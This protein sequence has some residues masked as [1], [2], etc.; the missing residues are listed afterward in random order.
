MTIVLMPQL[1]NEPAQHLQT[2]ASRRVL[3]ATNRKCFARGASFAGGGRLLQVHDG[4]LRPFSATAVLGPCFSTGEES[5]S[6]RPKNPWPS[7]AA[8][9]AEAGTTVRRTIETGINAG[10]NIAC[11]QQGS[12]ATL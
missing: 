1:K 6:S 4:R 10:P 5:R 7:A 2:T 8:H 11:G 9:A 3:R 12:Q